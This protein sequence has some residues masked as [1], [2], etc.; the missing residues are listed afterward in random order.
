MGV[1]SWTSGSSVASET[2]STEKENAMSSP[3]TLR[4]PYDVRVELVTDTI[5]AHSKLGDKAASELAVHI[6]HTL[7]SIPEKIR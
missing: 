7:N 5:K 2:C 3:T 4:T 6:L 1:T